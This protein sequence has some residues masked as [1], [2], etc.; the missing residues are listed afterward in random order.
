MLE[1]DLRLRQLVTVNTSSICHGDWEGK[2][3]E[4]SGLRIVYGAVDITLREPGNNIEM[5]TD[6][7]HPEEVDLHQKEG[8]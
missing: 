2:V 5:G 1:V 6:G 7:W 8:E 3:L 4:V